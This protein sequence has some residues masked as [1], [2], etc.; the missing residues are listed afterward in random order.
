MK[1]EKERQL[2][3]ERGGEDRGGARSYDD[4]KA[5]FSINHSILSA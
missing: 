3:H 1:T 4:E 2:A 5:W